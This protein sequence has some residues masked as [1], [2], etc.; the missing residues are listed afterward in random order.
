MKK[1]IQTKHAI[2]LIFLAVFFGVFM[3]SVASVSFATVA[4]GSE[5]LF[6]NAVV[7][8]FAGVAENPYNSLAQQL[9]EKEDELAAREAALAT[10]ELS[11]E[12]TNSLFG[13]LGGWSLFV[14]SIL[15]ILLL[16]NF[17]FDI[18]RSRQRDGGKRTTYSIDLKGGPKG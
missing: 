10:K 9:Q 17:Y 14:S 12:S 1:K 15:L 18:R 3:Y 6:A 4:K 11:N 13:S 2:K 8:V 16:V 7:G 5:N